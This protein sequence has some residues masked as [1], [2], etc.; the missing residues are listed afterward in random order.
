MNKLTKLFLFSAGVLLMISCEKSAV[1]FNDK[2]VTKIKT[3]GALSFSADILPIF[4][5]N[6]GS[7]H[8][9]L[10][11]GIDANTAYAFISPEV[12]AG[13]PNASL[14]QTKIDGNHNGATPLPSE[15]EKIN[16]WITQGALNN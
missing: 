16:K 10:E 6:C 2:G 9:D 14:I 5:S 12:V 8:S 1:E 7:C 11:T 15:I 4:N 13:D 3:P